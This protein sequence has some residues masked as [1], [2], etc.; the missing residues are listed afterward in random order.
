MPRIGSLF[1]DDTGA[2]DHQVG[3]DSDARQSVSISLENTDAGEISVNS[4]APTP[5]DWDAVTFSTNFP[6]EL[7]TN[8]SRVLAPVDGVY[9]FAF[10]AAF[11]GNGTGVL[12]VG[13]L[14][15][16]GVATPQYGHAGGDIH[17]TALARISGSGV[18]SLTAGQYVE[19]VVEQ[20]SGAPL[21]L[22]TSGDDHPRLAMWLIH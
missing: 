9:G 20:D 22:I 8:P 10:N 7:V 3:T 21:D 16:D 4:G 15:I 11:A 14:T 6:Q 18:L 2:V 19:L 1:V 12:R 17:A 5:L 13:Y